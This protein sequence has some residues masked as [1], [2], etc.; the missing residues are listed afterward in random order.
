MLSPDELEASISAA[1]AASTA[2]KKRI[3]QRISAA[4]AAST[5]AKKRTAQRNKF[6]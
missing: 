5:A 2:A 6:D 1:N 3:A 4:N